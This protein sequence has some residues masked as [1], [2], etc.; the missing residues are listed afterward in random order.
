MV[1]DRPGTNPQLISESERVGAKEEVRIEGIRKEPRWSKK[2]VGEDA[3]GRY[4]A[5]TERNQPVLVTNHCN[6][7][8]GEK[9]FPS[10]DG[11]Q[12]VTSQEGKVYP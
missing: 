11:G 1:I 6:R 4:Q 5:V 7:E 9:G 10:L 8:G 2:K 12:K 3:G